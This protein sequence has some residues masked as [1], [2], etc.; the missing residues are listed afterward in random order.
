MLRRLMEYLKNTN[1]LLFIINPNI[2]IYFNC[3]SIHVNANGI[4]F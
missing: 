2:G 4:D 1:Y 3:A